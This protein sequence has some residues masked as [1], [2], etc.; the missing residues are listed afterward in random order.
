MDA[1]VICLCA[2]I[3]DGIAHGTSW[4]MRLADGTECMDRDGTLMD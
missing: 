2:H 4:A 3:T 1:P